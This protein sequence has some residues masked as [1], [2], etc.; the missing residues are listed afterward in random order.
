[1]AE[2][3]AQCIPI[4][5]SLD[6]AESQRFYTE[7]LGF[8]GER[9]GDYLLVKR[10]R[11]E[12]HFWLCDNP[13]YPKVTACYI[14]G[15]QVPELYREFKKRGVPG[16]SEFAVRPWNMKEFYIRDPHGNLLKFGCIPEEN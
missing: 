13:E 10:D 8:R 2:D 1:M 4:L 12:L 3:P 7:T 9:V 14:R 15:G 11:M 5:A 16:L 6:I